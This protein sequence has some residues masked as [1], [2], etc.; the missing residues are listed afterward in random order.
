[1]E[2]S[3]ISAVAEQLVEPMAHSL[4]KARQHVVEHL[5]FVTSSVARTRRSKRFAV[6]GAV[7]FRGQ[8]NR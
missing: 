3:A 1:M 5:H 2:R 7:N 6:R 4:V 8:A